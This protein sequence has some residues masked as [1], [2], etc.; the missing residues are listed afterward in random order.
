MS[1]LSKAIEKIFNVNNKQQQADTNTRLDQIDLA[2][3]AIDKITSVNNKQQQADTNTR[4]LQLKIPETASDMIKESAKTTIEALDNAFKNESAGENT[5][6]DTT[7]ESAGENS[8]IPIGGSFDLN[9]LKE[10]QKEQW[11]RED[12][13]RKETQA[14]EDSAL[15]R[16]VEDAKK[17]G[18]NPN[19]IN[20]QP[21]ASGGGITSATGIDYNGAQIEVE[22]YLTEIENML[23]RELKADE[24]QKDRFSDLLRGVITA[25]AIFFR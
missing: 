9:S 21:A 20:I 3:Q 11:A 1:W 12:E 24:N 8:V 5:I 18:I 13:I 19:L 15:Q 25:A 2:E 10:L 22:K 7:N 4:L 16:A 23:D 17:A 6:Q 14:R